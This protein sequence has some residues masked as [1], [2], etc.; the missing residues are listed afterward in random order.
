M[1]YTSSKVS[2]EYQY[3]R[4]WVRLLHRP[5]IYIIHLGRDPVS[6]QGVSEYGLRGRTPIIFCFLGGTYIRAL[7]G[8]CCRLGVGTFTMAII[9]GL[10]ILG[11]YRPGLR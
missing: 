2:T 4:H 6:N 9:S 5:L 11:S 1:V 8:G 10:K 7:Q 3:H